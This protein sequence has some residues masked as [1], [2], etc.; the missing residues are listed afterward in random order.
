M[1]NFYYFNT[2]PHVPVNELMIKGCSQLPAS[3]CEGSQGHR[4]APPGTLGV[5]VEEPGVIFTS[6]EWTRWVSN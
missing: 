2:L 5:H 3:G 1:W 6:P 4:P